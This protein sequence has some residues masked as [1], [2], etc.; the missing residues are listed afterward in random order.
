MKALLFASGMMA[1]LR[2]DHVEQDIISE[3]GLLLRKIFA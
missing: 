3:V 2:K 1:R